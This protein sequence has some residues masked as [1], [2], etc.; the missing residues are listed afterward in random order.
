MIWSRGGSTRYLW[1]PAR[2][3]AAVE[4]VLYS[5]GIYL[6]RSG[7]KFQRIDRS[8]QFALALAH[9]GFRNFVPRPV[10]YL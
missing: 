9:A 2:V 4:Y 8:L 3:A 1:K 10:I 6:S 7:L 5:Q